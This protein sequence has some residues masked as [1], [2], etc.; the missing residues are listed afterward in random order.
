MP[1]ERFAMRLRTLRLK[2]GLTQDALAKKIGVS[3]G[4]LARLEMGRHDPPLSRL[5]TLAKALGVPVAE[6]LA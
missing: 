2:K 1:P 6:L 4:Y 5:R 3:R